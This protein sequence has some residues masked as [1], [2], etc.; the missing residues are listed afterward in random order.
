MLSIFK[1]DDKD[2]QLMQTSWSALLNSLLRKPQSTSI[3]LKDVPLAIGDNV[4]NH[5]LGR[6]LQGWQIIRLRSA[7]TIFD[8]QDENQMQILTLVLNASAAV[9]VDIEVF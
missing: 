1:N 4:I 9:V 2:F 5:K 7:A 8:K 3:I 6:K